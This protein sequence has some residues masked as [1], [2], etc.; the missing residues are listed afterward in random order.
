MTSRHALITGGAGFIGSHLAEHL[1]DEGHRVTVLDDLS[2]GSIGNVRHL[3][4]RES[5]RIL[6]GSAADEALLERVA[7]DADVLYHL[8]AVVGVRKVM[9][10]TVRTIETN[11]HSTEAVLRV[12]NRFRIR[13]LLTS[14]SEVY[15]AGTRERLSEEDDEIIGPSHYRRWCYAAGKLLD[16]FHAYAYH[17]S[18]ALPVTIVRLF[19]T[20]GPRQVGHYGMVVPTFV[21]QA[22]RGEP[23][24]VHGD[25]GQSRCFTWVG[26]VVR[27]LVALAESTDT[28]GEV[29]N[30][31]SDEEVTVRELAELVLE[32]TGSDSGIVTKSYR[33]VYGEDFVD[34]RRRHPDTTKLRA[35]LGFAPDTP[36]REALRQVIASMRAEP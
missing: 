33:E 28:V 30:V 2:T 13:T 35:A 18:T 29:Y 22:L 14:T 5:F 32:L 9:H 15:G 26:D 36:L 19:N 25:G 6:V 31:G 34:M 7:A 1:L 3:E 21:R 12:A 11:L 24:T 16:E 20:I 23:L 17:Y 27:A 4:S 10:D 8:A